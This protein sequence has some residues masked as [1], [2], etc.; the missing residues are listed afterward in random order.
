PLDKDFF[1]TNI[2]DKEGQAELLNQSNFKNFIRGIHLSGTGLD[3]LMFLLDISRAS[4]RINYEYQDYDTELEEVVTAEKSYSLGFLAST[5]EGVVGN[6]VN[7][8]EGDP[9]PAHIT[10]ALDN[11]ENASRIYL[12][13]GVAMA[14]IRLFDELV[15]GGSQLIDQIRANNWIVNEA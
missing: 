10:D 3:E 9:L 12:K 4:I 7:V 6:A 13:G 2:L 8:F 14:E 1:Q 15:N 11:G 5:T